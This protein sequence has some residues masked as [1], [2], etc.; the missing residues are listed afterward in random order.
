MTL[1]ANY[2]CY[3]QSDDD[4]DDDNDDDDDDDEWAD[5]REDKSKAK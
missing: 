1:V 4:D 2:F 3:V 5:E